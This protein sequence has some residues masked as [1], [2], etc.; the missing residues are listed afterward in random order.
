MFHLLLPR[1]RIW[2]ALV[3]GL[4]AAQAGAESPTRAT[5]APFTGVEVTYERYG[6]AGASP[7]GRFDGS[8]ATP[9]GTLRTSVHA[10]PA[11]ERHFWRGE[12]SFELAAPVLGGQLQ[13][14]ELEAGG[15]AAA[16]RT[17]LDAGLSAESLSEWTPVRSGQ[18]LKLQQK[19]G[20]GHVAAQALLSNSKTADVQGLRWDLEF[21]QEIGLVRWSAGVDTAERSYVSAGGGQEPRVGLRLGTQ[22]RL[23]PSTQMEARFTRQVRWDAESAVSS[24][25]L[26]TRFDLPWRTTLWTGLETDAEDRHKASL[27][28]TVPLE[29]R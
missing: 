19:L 9:A 12:T 6:E 11:G 5:V 22:W 2:A 15:T 26:G 21:A 8:V 7:P 23:F 28:L 17:R 14:R 25:M 16:W 3:V 18:A 20:Q 24:I 29:L 10:V 27:M 4:A 1:H 13:F